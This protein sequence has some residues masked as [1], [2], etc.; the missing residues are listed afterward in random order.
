MGLF[1]SIA[2]AVGEFFGIAKSEPQ[3]QI[4]EHHEPDKI[5]AAEIERD[6]ARI[7]HETQ[8][9]LAD[10]EAERIRMS[11]EA[12]LDIIEAQTA[13]QV[14]IEKA[15]AEGMIQVAET[16]TRMQDKMLEIAEKRIA[17]I[18]SASMQTVREIEKFYQEI[19]SQILSQNDEY[20]L[21]KL[22]Q[23]L[24]TLNKFEENSPAFNLYIAQIDRDAQRQVQFVVQQL[25][26][27]HERQDLVIRSSIATKDKI[28]E[29]TGH[30][31]Q[32]ILAE[33]KNRQLPQI[34]SESELRRGCLPV[35]DYF[36]CFELYSTFVLDFNSS[37]G[38][39]TN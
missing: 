24:D 29:Q 13:S 5:R 15:R 19:E 4:I 17:I 25:D 31:V 18:E 37:I 27:L 38:A 35:E 21:K 34:D 11:Q 12:Q 3:T 32:N 14:A 20:N 28:L 7:E 8:I 33:Q 26:K 9:R 16:L 1:S 23:L 36:I 2:K 22:P 10:R 6:R 39:L 30:I